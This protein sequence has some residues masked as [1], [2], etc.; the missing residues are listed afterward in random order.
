NP[1]NYNNYNNTDGSTV[2]GGT[3][4]TSSSAAAA[5]R[6][7]GKKFR[8]NLVLADDAQGDGAFTL[9][10]SC[11]IERYYRVA[12]R[13]LQQFLA[14]DIS[15]RDGMIES[16]LIGNRL[17]KFLSISL[18]THNDY[19][20]K[21]EKLSSLRIKSQ[22]QLIELLEYME[23]LEL[24]IDEIEYNHHLMSNLNQIEQR[25]Q[26][27]KARPSPGG[28]VT[29]ETMST[30]R[31]MS[32]E[33]IS[34]EKKAEDVVLVSPVNDPTRPPLLQQRS[35]SQQRI[36]QSAVD[37]AAVTHPN[38]NISSDDSVAILEDIGD[39]TS[40]RQTAQPKRGIRSESPQE[41]AKRVAAVVAASGEGKDVPSSASLTLRSLASAASF[42]SFSNNPISRTLSNGSMHKPPPITPRKSAVKVRNNHGPVSPNS[43]Q[44]TF[45]SWGNSTLGDL[46]DPFA[47]DFQSQS[48]NHIDLIADDPEFDPFGVVPKEEPSRRRS[49]APSQKEMMKLAMP[50]LDAKN[51][52][53]H[54]PSAA[55]IQPRKLDAKLESVAI[56]ESQSVTAAG[57]ATAA[58]GMSSDVFFAVEE[59]SGVTVPSSRA[60]MAGGPQPLEHQLPG[61]QGSVTRSK[62]EERLESAARSQ[63]MITKEL[64][65]RRSVRQQQQQMQQQQMQQDAEDDQYQ[66]F[67]RLD[68][69]SI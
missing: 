24:M 59:Q 46:V 45:V 25:K 53:E 1:H 8:A 48:S 32:M 39:P 14:S 43:D 52:K 60:I 63:A 42:D 16:Y 13:V 66:S 21:D 62:I 40:A 26:Q 19:F 51:S 7:H 3:N 31:S 15:N 22:N 2:T 4:D 41:F 58:S 47:S 54:A 6:K 29:D 11:T 28:H 27:Q 55:N 5:W 12:D 49:R 36:K 61:E 35:P 37:S 30:S 33:D 67:S 68:D 56:S 69:S 23:E 57:S 34:E 44:R 50:Q 10:E 9:N 64:Q 18:P 38:Q 17:F 65:R 20:S